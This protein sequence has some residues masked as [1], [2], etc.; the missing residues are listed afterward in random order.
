MLVAAMNPCPCGYATD[1]EKECF[2][3]PFQIQ[4]YRNK[5]SG[6]LLDR[7]DLHL[8]VGRVPFQKLGQI[9]VGESSQTISKRVNKARTLQQKRFKDHKNIQVNAEMSSHAVKKYCEIDDTSQT[10]LKQ[11]MQ[12]FHLSARTY[13]RILKVA[14]TIADIEDSKNITSAHIAEAIQYRQ[15]D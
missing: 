10:L 14:R 12:S 1:S 4:R 8:E 13:Y 15:R 6:P 11:A 7:I 5:I 2:C 3:T 9:E